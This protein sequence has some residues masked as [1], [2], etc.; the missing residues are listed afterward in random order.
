METIFSLPG[1]GSFMVD[2]IRQRDYPVIQMVNLVFA[3][4]VII[5]N[6]AVDV[7]YCLVDPRISFGGR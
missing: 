3:S 4:F 7:S 6:I 2:A 1:M 5:V